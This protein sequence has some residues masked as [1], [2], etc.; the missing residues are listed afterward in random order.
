MLG[1]ILVEK[2]F[3]L[4]FSMIFTNSSTLVIS[5]S[6][7][8]FAIFLAIFFASFSSPRILIIDTN[9]DSDKLLITYCADLSVSPIVI[10]KFFFDLNEKPLSR[11]LSCID[12]SP[13][14]RIIV[15]TFSFFKTVSI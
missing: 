2:F 10:S 6:T 15:S 8:A 1:L 13:R 7:L 9:C 14:S 3:F 4:L 5:F 12:E 11:L